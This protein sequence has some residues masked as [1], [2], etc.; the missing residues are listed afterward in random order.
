MK[1]LIPLSIHDAVDRQL[2]LMEALENELGADGALVEHSHCS[3]SIHLPVC[4]LAWEQPALLMRIRD[5]FYD[6]NLYVETDF[7]VDLPLGT[8]YDVQDFAWYGEQ[9]QKKADYCFCDW[10]A[11]EV[12]DPRILRVMRLRREGWSTVKPEEKD[13][14]LARMSSTAWYGSDWASGELLAEGPVPFTAET[15][16]YR[17]ERAFA[18]GIPECAPPYRGRSKKFILCLPNWEELRRVSKLIVEHVKK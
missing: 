14:W 5:N 10:S 7:A 3:K 9:M 2:V 15:R 4:S 11:E 8:F 1:T 17:A 13:R 18:E 6:V 16:F 12:N